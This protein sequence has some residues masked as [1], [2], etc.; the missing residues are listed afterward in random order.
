M[1][2]D[3]LK[4]HPPRYQHR[5]LGF[6]HPVLRIPMPKK[7]PV[8]PQMTVYI[9]QAHFHHRRLGFLYPVLWTP[10]PKKC[11]VGARTTVYISLDLGLCI[12]WGLDDMYWLHRR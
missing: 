3:T 1:Y 8:K 7:Y 10:V 11:R 12:N 2:E 9:S 5:R 4:K 6:L